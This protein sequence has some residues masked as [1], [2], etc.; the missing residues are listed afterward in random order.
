MVAFS[1][2]RL[3]V[4]DFTP[5]DDPTTLSMI[6][7]HEAHVMPPTWSSVSIV[8]SVSAGE[9]EEEDDDDEEEDLAYAGPGPVTQPKP[10]R[11]LNLQPMLKGAQGNTG[12]SLTAPTAL[13]FARLINQIYASQ[14]FYQEAIAKNPE[15]LNQIVA[16][17]AGIKGDFV[18][19][20]PVTV[21]KDLEKVSFPSDSA[22]DA[23]GKML[24]GEG[25]I[26]RLGDH[27][28]I[29]QRFTPIRMMGA[30]DELLRAIYRDPTVVETFKNRRLDL[31]LAVRSK[32][33]K[34]D[35]AKK[36]L[37]SEFG[38][39]QYLDINAQMLDFTVA[40]K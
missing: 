6:P 8:S 38:R 19:N 17:V 18:C 31:S 37:A 12:N 5:S 3:T 7:T 25:D 35:E 21:L 20:A 4:T 36:A 15:L 11:K 1:V 10:V 29:R 33:M 40:T 24:Q 27:I 34:A 30:S 16:T 32:R 9:D 28:V 13:L 23:F 39:E 22:R 26:P 2:T 14:P